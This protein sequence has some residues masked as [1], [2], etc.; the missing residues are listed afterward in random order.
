MFKVSQILP[1]LTNYL[2]SSILW[3][4]SETCVCY[5]VD[6]IYLVLIIHAVICIPL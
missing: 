2:T 3:R 1:I 4:T 5:V 6:N